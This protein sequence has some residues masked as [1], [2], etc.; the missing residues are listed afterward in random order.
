MVFLFQWILKTPNNSLRM[1][2]ALT[3]TLD[4]ATTCNI[5]AWNE[6]SSRGSH[7]ECRIPVIWKLQLQSYR[8]SDWHSLTTTSLLH[9]SPANIPSGCLQI[10]PSTWLSTPAPKGLSAAT[11]VAPTCV[12]S[13]L[14]SSEKYSICDPSTRP[15]NWKE[16][17]SKVALHINPRLFTGNLNPRTMEDLFGVKIHKIY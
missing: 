15:G 1:L 11:G 10:D 12:Q 16:I 3:D 2:K 14:N 4:A 6:R 5:A 13:S 17:Y 8:I 9:L 7:D